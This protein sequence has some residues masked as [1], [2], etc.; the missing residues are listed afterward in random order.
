LR[1]EIERD[2]FLM[3]CSSVGELRPSMLARRR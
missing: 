2:M 3:G 1:D